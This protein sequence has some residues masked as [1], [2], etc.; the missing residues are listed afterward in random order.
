MATIAR[1]GFD[2]VVV[3]VIVVLDRFI[4]GYIL[5]PILPLLDKLCR[6]W[7]ASP[8]WGLLRSGKHPV[9]LKLLDGVMAGLMLTPF[10]LFLLVGVG[11]YLLLRMFIRF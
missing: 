10:V 2:I 11:L 7:F 9:L 3:F 1:I 5:P 6:W 4:L 8:R